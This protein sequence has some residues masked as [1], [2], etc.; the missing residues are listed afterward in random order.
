MRMLSEVSYDNKYD[1]HNELMKSIGVDQDE[2]EADDHGMLPLFKKGL[3]PLIKLVRKKI[4][5]Y[6]KFKCRAIDVAMLVDS[7]IECCI[8]FAGK[9]PI[10]HQY[11]KIKRRINK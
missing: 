2:I 3:M 7:V 6:D 1:Q 10:I 9:N 11:F 8:K 4:E 5:L